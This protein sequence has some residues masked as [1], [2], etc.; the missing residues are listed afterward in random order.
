MFSKWT[1]VAMLAFRA[2]DDID[3][4]EW[5]APDSNFARLERPVTVRSAIFPEGA[6]WTQQSLME[7]NPN[8]A[9]V[10]LEGLD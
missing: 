2:K 3:A 5:I 7:P 1:G 8:G 6:K 9:V 4:A 10:S